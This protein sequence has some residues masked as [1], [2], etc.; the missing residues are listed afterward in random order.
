M[1]EKKQGDRRTAIDR[2]KFIGGVGVGVA[3]GLAGCGGGPSDQGTTAGP[4]GATETEEPSGETEGPAE[5]TTE[6]TETP[7]EEGDLVYGGIPVQGQ[8][9]PPQT[10]N[11]LLGGNEFGRVFLTMIYDNGLAL[12]PKT[13]RPIPWIFTDWELNVDNIGTG[14]PTIVGT[15]RDD[16]T[17]HDGKKLTAEDV[18]FTQDYLHEQNPSGDYWVRESIEAVE[19]D[20]PKGTTVSYF[21]TE[22]DSTWIQSTVGNLILPKHIWENVSDYSQYEPRNEGGPIGSGP[23]KWKDSNWPEWVELEMRPSEEVPWNGDDRYPWLHPEGPF[24]DGVRFQIYQDTSAL[25][26]AVLNQEVDQTYF[27]VNIDRA[28]RA[29]ERDYLQIRE[30][31]LSGYSMHAYNTRRVPFDDVAFRQ[32]LGKAVNQKWI[33]E[34]L[35][36]GFSADYGD[37]VIPRPWKDWRPPDPDEISGGYTGEVKTD[38]TIPIPDLSYPRDTAEYTVTDDDVEALRNFL[39]GHTAAKHDYSLGPAVTDK[40]NAPDG[41]EIYVNGIPISEAHTNNVGEADQGPL[42][43]AGYPPESG[44]LGYEIVTKYINALRTIGLPITR[45]S[46]PWGTMFPKVYLREEFD[47]YTQPWPDNSWLQTH[48]EWMLSSNGADLELQYD[49]VPY[50][51][52]TAYTGADE[53]IMPQLK[54]MSI[55]ERKPWVKK[56][57]AKVYFD[58]PQYVTTYPKVLQPVNKRWVGYTQRFGSNGAG[59]NNPYNWLNLRKNPE[60]QE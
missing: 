5:E 28:V 31:W 22:K 8:D 34:N 54:L 25:F 23:L 41:Q 32:F 53:Y 20:S 4:G 51:N 33:V 27:G 39:I 19:V 47:M 1:S 50:W 15:I 45:T 36:K 11:I 58:Q 46:V 10:S 29:A 42:E 57:A 18:K 56:A 7:T 35:N 37:Y 16:V 2:R 12:N 59:V 55:E 38:T 60:S 30:A 26:Q 14:D 40:S 3:A 21:L 13:S 44:E 43:F 17:F 52:S 6:A 48:F 9:S 49:S 24:V